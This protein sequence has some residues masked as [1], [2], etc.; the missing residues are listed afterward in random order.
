MMR[1]S[2]AAL[3]V[4]SLAAGARADVVREA[5]D[6]YSLHTLEGESVTLDD[7][8]GRTVVVNFWAEWCGPCRRELPVLDA[9]NQELVGRDVVFA[10]ISIDRDAKKAA[11]LADRLDLSLPLYHDGP[12]DLAATL[13]LPSLPITYVVGP[14]GRTVFTSNGSDPETMDALHAAIISAAPRSASNPN[15]SRGAER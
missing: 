4:L 8:E 12:D 10:A 15:P 9:W 3:M 1:F 13:D 14:D 2:F 6:G 11:R 7:L 5:I